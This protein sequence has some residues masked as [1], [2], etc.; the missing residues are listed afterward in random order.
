MK[1]IPLPDMRF[2]RLQVNFFFL[3]NFTILRNK[4]Q[5]KFDTSTSPSGRAQK[6][7]KYFFCIKPSLYLDYL[8]IKKNWWKY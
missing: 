1:S 3:L 5:I 7:S 8:F 2:H 4:Q 6:Q